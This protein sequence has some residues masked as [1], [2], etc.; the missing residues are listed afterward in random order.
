M[1]QNALFAS[2]SGQPSEALK[3]R[4]ALRLD[5]YGYETLQDLDHE[6][7][8][9]SFRPGV[10]WSIGPRAGV[11]RVFSALEVAAFDGSPI[12][13]VWERDSFSGGL[14]VEQSVPLPLPGSMVSLSF[15]WLR[16]VT[17]A[18]TGG[19]SDGFDGDYDSDSFRVRALG[20]L[21]LPFSMRA[22]VEAAYSRDE[23]LNDNFTRWID[24]GD[25]EPREDDLS[26]AR[27]SLSRPILPFTRL[28]VYWR[29]FWRASNV[30]TYDYDKNL[31]GLLVHVSSE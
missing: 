31:V 28:E 14:G 2:L 15:T 26:A 6:L 22:Q 18:G 12:L 4:L 13:D 20:S 11:V 9:A 27:I 16:T 23:Y 19:L 10:L 5:A 3:E 29:G 17:E 1:I 25:I 21:V 30:A 8:G 24:T 7:A